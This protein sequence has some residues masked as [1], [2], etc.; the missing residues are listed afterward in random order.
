[1]NQA[2]VRRRHAGATGNEGTTTKTERRSDP[3]LSPERV[4]SRACY[5]NLKSNQKYKQQLFVFLLTCSIEFKIEQEIQTTIQTMAGRGWLLSLGADRQWLGL[6]RS[7]C[8]G[9]LRRGNMYISAYSPCGC[10]GLYVPL[11]KSRQAQ[12]LATGHQNSGTSGRQKT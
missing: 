9:L 10:A 4:R 6:E 11:E 7:S 1:M 8:E 3:G 12:C 5:L 2:Q